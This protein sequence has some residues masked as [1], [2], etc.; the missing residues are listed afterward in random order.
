MRRSG[1]RWIRGSVKYNNLFSWSW[2]QAKNLSAA[3]RTLVA[4]HPGSHSWVLPSSN[5]DLQLGPNFAGVTGVLLFYKVLIPV[6]LWTKLIALSQLQRIEITLMRSCLAW[7]CHSFV[8]NPLQIFCKLEI[9]IIAFV[10]LK[11]ISLRINSRLDLQQ[12]MILVRIYSVL[13]RTKTLGTSW[14][15]QQ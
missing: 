9:S 11:I 1:V 13:V 14:D 3:I 5:V 12:L 8:V 15:M 10:F 2:V 4:A 7:V 6:L